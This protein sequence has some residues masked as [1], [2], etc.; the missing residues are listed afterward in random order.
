MKKIFA[1]SI[2]LF[3]LLSAANAQHSSTSLPELLSNYFSIKDALIKSDASSASTK[4]VEF[5]KTIKSID[6]N[7]LSAID[8]NAFQGVKEKLMSDAEHIVESKNISNQRDF[9]KTLSANFSI[10]AKVIKLSEHPIYQQY[11]PMKKAYWLSNEKL[12]QNPYYGSQML[13]CGSV[14]ATM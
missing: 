6:V 13:T 5:V 12:I 2:I 4:A 1:I 10:L 8:N 14:T 11:C 3:S 9:F 7:T